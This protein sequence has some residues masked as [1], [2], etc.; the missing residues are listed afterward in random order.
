MQF[1]FLRPAMALAIWA[2]ASAAWCAE[3]DPAGSTGAV[4]APANSLATYVFR[5]P[6]DG[7]P[8]HDELGCGVRMGFQRTESNVLG[9]PSA[10]YGRVER[11]GADQ[12]RITTFRGSEDTAYGKGER[13]QA[14][15]LL[16]RSPELCELTI[17][18]GAS[19]PYK[20][21]SLTWGKPPTF[22]ARDVIEQ[23]PVF[24][25]RPS[26]NSPFPAASVMANFD[27]LANP[28][29]N[30][31]GYGISRNI[32]RDLRGRET[33]YC[34]KTESGNAPFVASCMPYRDGSKCIVL[35]ILP[36]TREGTTWDARSQ[37]STFRA[38]IQAILSD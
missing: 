33:M 38:A 13:T 21:G 24:V 25:Y 7:D 1:D 23:T 36:A 14:T 37:A 35:T 28:G 19:E 6:G 4:E 5:M 20:L 30:G 9:Q 3:P 29:C 15:L 22:T 18:L 26:F 34:A 31:V 11:S 32:P 17:T 2:C 12:A 27:R 8:Q 16:T 10:I